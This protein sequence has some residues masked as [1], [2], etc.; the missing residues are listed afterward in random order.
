MTVSNFLVWVPLKHLN[1]ETW[2]WIRSAEEWQKHIEK[3]PSFT[4]KNNRVFHA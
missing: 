3:Q 4:E 2:F 1:L